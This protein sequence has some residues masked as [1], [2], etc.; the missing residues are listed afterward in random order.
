MSSIFLSHSSADNFEAIALRDWLAAEGWDDVFLD[1]D[2]ERGIAAGER[3]ERALHEAATRCEAVIFLVSA[4]WLASGWCLKE[5]NL[6]RAL[7]KKLFAVII[8]R[9]KLI[10]D[11]PPELKGTWQVVDLAGGQ[12][13]QLTRVRPPGSHEEKHVVFSKDGLKRLKRGLDKAGLDPKF[14][15]WPPDTDG[16][17]A[18]Y[19]GLKP[20]E[21][22]DAGVFFGREAPI[23]E[24][25]DRLRGLKA[26]APPR[27]LVILGASGAG[28]SS[29]LRAGLLPRLA[30]DERNFLA[31]PVIRPERA[32]LTGENGLLHALDA[33]LPGHTRAELRTAI[34]AGA[35]GVRPLLKELV[36][37]SLK[38]ASTAQDS[39]KPPAVALAIDQAEELLRPE[40]AAEGGALLEL[41]RDLTRGDDPAVIAIFAIRSDSY[42]ALEHAKPL[43]GLAQSA[44]PLLPMPRGA[45]KDVIEGPARRYAEAGNALTIEP[46]LTDRL[47][48]DIDK[49]GGS[50]ALPLLAFTLEQ[51]FLDYRRSGALRLTNYEDFGG[52]KGAIDAA[53]ERAFAR[54][55]ADPRIPKER[56]ARETLLRRGFIP[57]LAGVDPDSKSPRRNIARRAEIPEEA[58]PLIDLLV[59]ERLLATDTVA[60][61][62][63]A[64]GAENR[65]VTIEPAHEALLRQWGLL[66]G[67]LEEDFG[68]LATLEG[69]KR[70]AR[71]WNA[72]ARAEA[73][74]AHQGPRLADA[75]ALDARPDIAARLDAWDR[76][77]LAEC[78]GR[79]A[80]TVAEKERAQ[81]NALALAKAQTEKAQARA[82]GA[83]NL[84]AVFFVAAVALAGVGGW[85]WVQRNEA[86]SQKQEALSQK[87]IA[88][89]EARRAAD[90]KSI[91][92]TAAREAEA[93]KTKAESATAE[94]LKQKANADAAAVE[95]R[96]QTE[97]AEAATSAAEAATADAKAQRDRA[98]KTLG[99]ANEAVHSLIFDIAQ[100]LKDVSGMQVATIHRILDTVKTTINALAATEPGDKDLQ[101]SRL[102]MFGNFGD[103]YLKAGDLADAETAVAEALAVARTLAQDK[104][105]GLAQDDLTAT[106]DR[107]GDVKLQ[108]G[109]L[110]GALAAYKESLALRRERAKDKGNA[111]AQSD[112]GNSLERIGNV[113][114][115]AGDPSG[116]LAAYEEMLA[117]DRSIDNDKGNAE[118]RRNISVDLNRIGNVKLQAGDT[119]GARA[120]YE[121]S[122]VIDRELAEDK[123][124]ADAQRDLSTTLKKI[125]DVKLKS[126]DLAGALVPYEE[127]LMIGRELAKDKGNAEAQRDVSIALDRIGDVKL[128]AGDRDEALDAYAESLAIR[129]ELAK[130]DRNARARSDLSISLDRIG[131][132]KLQAGD[133]NGALA[134]Y[135]E[136][137]AIRRELAADKDDADA[138][139]DLSISLDRIGNMKLRADDRAGALAAYQESLT[140]RRELAKDKGNAE[141]QRGL[142]VS[143]VKIGSMKLQAGDRDGALAAY[144][145]SL[146]TARLLAKDKEDDGAQRDLVV[147]LAKVAELS[148]E[149]GPLYLEALKNLEERNR[150]RRLPEEQQA[151]INQIKATLAGLPPK[152]PLASPQAP[153][154][155]TIPG[156]GQPT[157]VTDCDRLA[158]SNTDP[159]LPAGIVGVPFDKLDGQRAIPVCRAA[160]EANPGVPRLAFELARSLQHEKQYEEALSMYRRAA[161]AGYALAWNNLGAMYENGLG[162]AIDETE[163][164]RL[165]RSAADTGNPLALRNLAMM[166]ENG[167]GV[168][169][170]MAEAIHLYGRAADAG[171]MA[172]AYRLGQIYE[173]GLGVTKDTAE[174]IRQYTR[175]ADGKYPPAMY[176]LG[177]LYESGV[178]GQRDH[179]QATLWIQR[180][181]DLNYE[182]AKQELRK[183]K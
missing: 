7:N 174:A 131:D 13:G 76:T 22:V 34:Q 33:V 36:A 29:F 127:S 15:A 20:L 26:G 145:E 41:V 84:T 142:A 179:A 135:E 60:T 45:Y 129:R 105:N 150:Q 118:T 161:E 14:F 102:A 39:A 126:G 43:E 163:A 61:K 176:E 85:A 82:R 167:R 165:F 117:I 157:S 65:I 182:P 16:E 52:L 148:S 63:A 143:L 27:L 91:A 88:D 107:F 90:E 154:A 35:A 178:A 62:D 147:S 140:L 94:A 6:A 133:E 177:M 46:Q 124:N 160:L 18:P 112:L 115:Q 166:Y 77:Y 40:G 28:K 172:A 173:D 8:D 17:R 159:S 58:A 125:G 113:K 100:G 81:A 106:L 54:A 144:E 67:W 121:E 164:V 175:A 95:A 21:G 128:R 12:D 99:A 168:A 92:D 139:F 37:A 141:A 25:T 180:A 59:E 97:K 137:L 79:E 75:Q 19:R 70:A 50:D 130:D 10:A 31:L 146:A 104:G 86:L 56:K 48:E 71:D 51:L 4:H 98:E 181:A 38:G 111:R 162:V 151:W 171:E 2:P 78:G 155:A 11:L 93:Q 109:D 23:V 87:Q 42:D 114:L 152:A 1:L 149:P 53:V 123:G 68:L 183:L 49:G 110:A 119:E 138:Q 44:L 89:R 83:R 158:S 156:A 55:G 103:T 170:D 57:W 120:A 101:R 73:W 69:V 169:K 116:A 122:L 96:A 134:A 30:R 32:A 72:N 47:L 132:I 136:G 3:W 153:P 108:A 5:Y 9:G 66:Q 64:T 80:A 24:A 74:L